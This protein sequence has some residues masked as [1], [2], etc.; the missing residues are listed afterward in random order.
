MERVHDTKG[1]HRPLRGFHGHQETE[2]AAAAN[3]GCD[4]Q[5]E[6]A[7]DDSIGAQPPGIG[8]LREAL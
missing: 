3:G 5:A 2:Q 6:A 1:V 7:A 8:R 4:H